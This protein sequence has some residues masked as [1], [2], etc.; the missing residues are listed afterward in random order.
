MVCHDC[1]NGKKDCCDDHHDKNRMSTVKRAVKKVRSKRIYRDQIPLFD[2]VAVAVLAYFVADSMDYNK[3]VWML[4]S[5]PATILV[6]IFL[7]PPEKSHHHH[8]ENMMHTY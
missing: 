6:Y 5:V 3:L 7:F 4:A 1:K 2:V 8:H